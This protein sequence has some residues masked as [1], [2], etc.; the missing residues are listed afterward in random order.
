MASVNPYVLQGNIGL[1]L[2]RKMDDTMAN[3]QM[4]GIQ[5]KRRREDAFV[6]MM[7]VATVNFVKDK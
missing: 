1:D 6:K 3:I 5:E 2:Q 7:D 4:L